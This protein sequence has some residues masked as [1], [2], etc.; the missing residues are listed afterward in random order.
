MFRSLRLCSACFRVL[1]HSALRC[2]LSFADTAPPPCAVPLHPLLV[3]VRPVRKPIPTCM[4]LERRFTR[5]CRQRTSLSPSGCV[6]HNR[7]LFPVLKIWR[8]TRNDMNQEAHAVNGDQLGASSSSRSGAE[9]DMF[10][11][12]STTSSCFAGSAAR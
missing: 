11:Q 3:S 5:R 4:L 12:R 2:D 8:K 7:T 6:R 10:Q 9:E 1:R